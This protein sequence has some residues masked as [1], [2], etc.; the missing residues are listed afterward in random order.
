VERLDLDPYGKP[1]AGGSSVTDPK[2]KGSTLGFQ[3]AITDKVSGSVVLGPRLYDPSTA[4]FSTADSF[5]AGG[6]DLGLAL[7]SPP[8]TATSSPSQPRGPLRRRPRPLTA[9][10]A[11]AM[12]D[13]PPDGATRRWVARSGRPSLRSETLEADHSHE[14]GHIVRSTAALRGV[15]PRQRRFS[16]PASEEASGAPQLSC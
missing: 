11:G 6:L 4:R 9:A 8:A 14:A 13:I 7:E 16:E 10:S 2:A 12:W 3:G 5:V 15:D 1:Q